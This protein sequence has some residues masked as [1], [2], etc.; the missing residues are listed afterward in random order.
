M[1]DSFGRRLRLERERRHIALTS[2]A[3]STKISIAL[4]QGLERDD[5]SRWPGGIF[6]RSFFRTYA[7]AVGLDSEALLREFMIAFPDPHEPRPDAPRV[8][9]PR[10]V[11]RSALRLTLDERWSPF[12]AGVQLVGGRTRLAAAAW[13]VAVVIAVATSVF[14]LFDRF[15]LPLGLSS[16]VYYVG[17]ILALGNTPGVCL[18]APVSANAAPSPPPTTRQPRENAANQ[19]DPLRLVRRA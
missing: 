17:G 9:A 7:D 18:F 5:L 13:D 14:V 11:G 16:L 8:A 2:I 4:L 6:R 12:S 1:S 19:R 15:W 10:P 3:D